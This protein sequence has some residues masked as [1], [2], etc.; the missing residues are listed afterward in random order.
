MVRRGSTVRVRQRASQKGQQMA[1][2][3]P[4]WPTYIARSVP[5]P[6]PRICPNIARGLE[7]WLKQRRLTSSSTSINGRY[8]ATE[9][10]KDIDAS[11]TAARRCEAGRGRPF[12]VVERELACPNLVDLFVLESGRVSLQGTAR[13]HVLRLECSGRWPTR[14]LCPVIFSRRGSVG[15]LRGPPFG[16]DDPHRE[17]E[18]APIERLRELRDGYEIV[19]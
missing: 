19:A 10:R 12:R 14:R 17:V 11:D 5:Q 2:L 13:A 16:R 9:G 7:A 3:L 1:F 6:V 4:R 8:P 18:R 15:Q